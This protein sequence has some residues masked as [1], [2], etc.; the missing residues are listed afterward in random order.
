MSPSDRVAQLYSQAPGS[1]FVT[2][3]D[4][5][6][7][8]GDILI[9]LHTGSYLKKYDNERCTKRTNSNHFQL[10]QRTNKGWTETAMQVMTLS[11]P[12]VATHE[13]EVLKKIAFNTKRR[14]E[15]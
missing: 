2:F 9:H 12:S 11:C 14:S 3:Y 4:L 15:T 8:S 13:F 6:G 5:Q 10:T 1:V 7:Y